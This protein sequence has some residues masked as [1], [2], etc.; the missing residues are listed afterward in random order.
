MRA[1]LTRCW[2]CQLFALLWPSFLGTSVLADSNEVFPGDVWAARAPAEVGLAEADLAELARHVG[3]QG[4]VVRHGYLVY[5]WGDT[6]KSGD[7][8]S[9]VKPIISTLLL[10]AVQ[11]GR[12]KSVD[13]PLADVEP[14]LRDLN[15]GKDA[16]ITWRHLASQSSGYGLAEAPGEAYAYNDFALALY[17]DTLMNRV[18]QQ[19]GTRVLRERL[20]DLMGFQDHYTFDAFGRNDRAGR[21]AMSV[22]DL[23]RI[24]L[25]Y[26]RNGRWVNRQLLRPDLVELAIASPIPATLPRSAGKDVDMLPDQRTL[27]GGKNQ[28]AVGPGVYSFNWW[29]NR[30]DGEG[31][32]LFVDAP[33]D[34]Y[35][36]FG[37]GGQRALWIFPSL[38]LI[39]AWNDSPID[40]HDA[41]PGNASTRM[42]QAARIIRGAIERRTVVSIDGDRWLING[43]LVHAGSPAEGRLMNVRMVNATF[44][45]ANRPDFDADVNTDRFLKALPAYVAAGVRCFTLN[46]Q[47]G[48]PGYEG[49]VNSAFRP[50]GSLRPSYLNRVR[51]VVDAC[52]EL[53]VVVILGCF[54]QRQDQMLRDETA[55]RDGVANVAQWIKGCGFTNVVLEVANEFP[56]DGFDHALIRSPSGQAELIALAKRVHRELLVSTSGMGDGA[57]AD[58][59]AKAADFLLIHYNGTPV[60][61]IPSRIA[62]LRRFG[63]PIVCNEDDKLGANGA[64][65][66]RVSIEHGASWGFMSEA[67]NQHFP[68]RFDGP[69]DDLEVYEAI[70]QLTVRR[71]GE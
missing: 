69:A 25:L 36:A 31:N 4:C 56:H 46:L 66:A 8:A 42:N 21:L 71:E 70:K 50:D 18:Y 10:M 33:S 37:H 19:A 5:S 59:V 48:M 7:I 11:E 16:G 61:D 20:G 13:D 40:D 45:D 29:L 68:F 55:V 14:R 12:L 63:K 43:Q 57:A 34:V 64:A 22:R 15:G 49:A 62:A 32:R 41:S 52:D 24:G 53:G 47:G 23:A 28:T 60:E 9:A 39:V 27:G 2:T 6:A 30:I 3:G 65:A 67:V 38:D 1:C 26:L 17:Y 44:E 35:G 51:R 58:E 54:Y